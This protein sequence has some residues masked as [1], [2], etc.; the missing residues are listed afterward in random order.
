L[1]NILRPAL[2]FTAVGEGE[3]VFWSLIWNRGF[4]SNSAGITGTGD[5]FYPGGWITTA[6]ADSRHVYAT[7]DTARLKIIARHRWSDGLSTP[8]AGDARV[9]VRR[10]P[11]S[12]SPRWENREGDVAFD[13]LVRMGPYGTVPVEF[14]LT[15]NGA[16]GDWKVYLDLAPKMNRDAEMLKSISTVDSATVGEIPVRFRG[17]PAFKLTLEE[18]P[19]LVAGERAVFT[20]TAVLP[21]GSPL[22][23]GEA[24][25]ELDCEPG[26]GWHP[27]GFG[28][29]WSFLSYDEWDKKDTGVRVAEDA[30]GLAHDGTVTFE[31]MIPEDASLL[32]RHC[33]LSVTVADRRGRTVSR[34]SKFM[35]HPSSLNLGL[36]GPDRSDAPVKPNDLELAVASMDGTFVPGVKV[37]VASYSCFPPEAWRLDP[38]G[39]FVFGYGPGGPPVSE[40]E[41][42]SGEGP[43]A[44]EVTPDEEGCRC[45]KAEL[46]DPEGRKALASYGC[47]HH[48]ATSSFRR[49][50]P[51]P[52]AVELVADRD[53]YVPGDVARVVV[54]S[55]FEEGTGLVT[56][57]Q[58]GIR[59]AKTFDLAVGPPVMEFPIKESDAPKVYVSAV[60]ARGRTAT[61]PADGERGTY[62]EMDWDDE[63]Q[64]RPTFRVGYVSLRVNSDRS[65]LNVEVTPSEAE[66][67]PGDRVAVKVRVTTWDGT[68]FSDCEVSLAAEDEENF[69]ANVFRRGMNPISF[70]RWTHP[71]KVWTSSSLAMV[72]RRAERPSYVSEIYPDGSHSTPYPEWEIV[73][74]RPLG[75]LRRDIGSV[76][77]FAPQLMPD[78]N[79]EVEA[80]IA[81]PGHGTYRLTATAVGRDSAIGAGQ[82]RVTVRRPQDSRSR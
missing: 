38:G 62:G 48:S 46:T 19:D 49:L 13:G 58:D 41:V 59:L 50:Q 3:R 72:P 55:P 47:F 6:V 39:H 22:D 21:D 76:A 75:E 57:E 17:T 11:P 69:M 1:E 43:V 66:V 10:L 28:S 34:N 5:P 35:S 37:R 70:T 14:P 63:D 79:G 33:T 81:L 71:L 53:E 12:W 29:G 54:R 18:T 30:V 2:H 77:F 4:D 56:V 45:V 27:P 9:I 44:F 60:L 24:D 61:P 78:A 64:G 74:F 25:F 42:T 20:A 15:S 16:M 51:G 52:D 67:R 23:G 68:P 73:S 65:P 80:M 8:E 36:K 82:A 26:Y 31:A 32:A 7:D 40:Q